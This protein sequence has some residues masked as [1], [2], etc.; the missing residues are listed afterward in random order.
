[1]RHLN[2]AG[3]GQSQNAVVHLLKGKA[4]Q[5]DKVAGNVKCAYLA[6]TILKKL[7]AGSKAGSDKQ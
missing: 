6:T 1:M 2:D 5:I 3:F 7:K 4:V